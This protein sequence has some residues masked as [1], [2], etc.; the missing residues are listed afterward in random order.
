MRASITVLLLAVLLTFA[1]PVALAADA[2][3][4]DEI[5]TEVDLG[6]LMLVAGLGAISMV[7]MI[8]INRDRATD[9]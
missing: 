7:G 4:G 2:A 6:T 1:S 5:V 9:L 8:A 3:A